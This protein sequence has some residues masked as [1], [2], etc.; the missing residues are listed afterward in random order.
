MPILVASILG[1]LAQVAGSLVGRVLLALGISYVTFKGFGVATDFIKGQVQTSIN[2]MPAEV[3][4]L[5]GFLWVDKA[6][7]LVFSA[8][9]ACL[10]LKLA[11][12]DSVTNMIV[13]K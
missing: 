10:A 6:I 8:W 9:S 3:V 7:S 4:S 2:S 12:A 13:R 1:G 11:G 5:L